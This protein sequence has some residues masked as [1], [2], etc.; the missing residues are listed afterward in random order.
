MQIWWPVW[1]RLVAEPRW[2]IQWLPSHLIHEE[3]AAEGWAE[4]D[5]EGN[6]RAAKAAKAQA[7]V[8]DLTPELLAK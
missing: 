7:R 1:Q 4:E 5:W 3:S 6:D 8:T 2:T